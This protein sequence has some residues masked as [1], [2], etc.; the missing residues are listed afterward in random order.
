MRTSFAHNLLVRA[1]PVTISTIVLN[2]LGNPK[3]ISVFVTSIQGFKW[4]MILICISGGMRFDTSKWPINL[5]WYFQEEP[6]TGWWRANSSIRTCMR[7]LGHGGQIPIL[8]GLA[9][10]S[11]GW[12][13][14]RQLICAS[15]LAEFEILSF[16]RS[17]IK[18]DAFLMHWIL[19][20]VFHG[21]NVCAS[22]SVI[23]AS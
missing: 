22:S 3:F 23:Q 7:G 1:Y 6:L 9:Q 11:N 17:S 16:N 13:R 15:K 8:N 19:R 21:D 2:S 20:W 5:L 18:T 10:R 4:R 12:S 14:A